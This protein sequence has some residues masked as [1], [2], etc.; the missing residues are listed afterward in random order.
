M[1]LFVGRQDLLGMLKVTFRKP[2]IRRTVITFKNNKKLQ[3]LAA[4]TMTV[5]YNRRHLILFQPIY[6]DRVWWGNYR[7]TILFQHTDIEHIMQ[8]LESSRQ[9]QL[10]SI[11]SNY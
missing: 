3:L 5:C 2:L 11:W 9:S 7:A 6:F 4:T 1:S 10:V 8:S